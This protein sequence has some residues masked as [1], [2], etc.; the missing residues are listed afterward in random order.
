MFS[1]ASAILATPIKARITKPYGVSFD[2]RVGADLF[3]LHTLNCYTFGE[4]S[5]GI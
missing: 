3:A 2:C 4:L 5:S 1:I